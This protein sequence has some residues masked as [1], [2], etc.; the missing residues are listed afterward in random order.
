M[1]NNRFTNKNYIFERYLISQNNH[2]KDKIIKFLIENFYI[3]VKNNNNN[4]RLILQIKRH[5]MKNK[6]LQLN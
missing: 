6:I 4:Y 1:S 3:S 5:P 2:K